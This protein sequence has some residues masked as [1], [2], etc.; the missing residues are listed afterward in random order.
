MSLVRARTRTARS[1]VEPTNHGATA[2][3]K[4]IAVWKTAAIFYSPTST[5]QSIFHCNLI[6]HRSHAKPRFLNFLNEYSGQPELKILTALS[7]F[8]T[9]G[10]STPLWE[11]CCCY[12]YKNF[13][14]IKSQ[15][16]IGL[17]K[18]KKRE[19]V[20]KGCNRLQRVGF[21]F[22]QCL[23]VYIFFCC[24]HC[25]KRSTRYVNYF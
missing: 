25:Q 1:G 5:T 16:A 14:A 24:L 12:A 19:N 21:V 13:I 2:P 3:P 11:I 17:L 22:D 23:T 7:S 4:I 15:K 9:K 20:N 6:L 18:Q 8:Y 10:F